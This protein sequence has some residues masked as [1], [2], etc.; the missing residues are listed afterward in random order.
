[1]GTLTIYL[2]ENYEDWLKTA[3]KENSCPAGTLVKHLIDNFVAKPEA[4]AKDDDDNVE[5]IDDI[6]LNEE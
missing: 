3:C 4:Q 1:M 6:G 2:P 5:I